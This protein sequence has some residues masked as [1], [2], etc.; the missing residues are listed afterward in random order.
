MM[1][2][3]QEERNNA[4][5]VYSGRDQLILLGFDCEEQV[6]WVLGSNI[7]DCVR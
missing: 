3:I 1:M 4:A 6:Y 2:M 7:V 5:S